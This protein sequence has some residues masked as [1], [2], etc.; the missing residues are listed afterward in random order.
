MI[1]YPNQESQKNSQRNGF[2]LVEL[3]VV[4]AIIGMLSSVVLGSLNSAR[5]KARDAR[6]KSDLTTLRSAF[7]LVADDNSGTYPA[8]L[9]CLGVTSA[10]R[11]W[12]GYSY[13]S[14]GTPGVLGNTTL[15]T[16]LQT[17]LPNIPADPLPT[18][19]VGDAYVYF[20]GIADT[21]C[22]GGANSISGAWLA[23]YPDS[24]TANVSSC[25]PGTWACCSQIGC[26]SPSFCVLKID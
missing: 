10:S 7:A 3:L 19:S 24:G 12:N 8:G 14:G 1:F 6:R 18:R 13:N 20:N 2:T 17:R 22:T 11:C 21:L 23:W 26:G 9:G 16:A 4:I 25:S 5:G 15:N